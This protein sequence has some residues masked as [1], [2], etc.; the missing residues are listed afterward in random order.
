MTSRIRSHKFAGVESIDEWPNFKVGVSRAF[1]CTFCAKH[2][3]FFFR[4]GLIVLKLVKLFRLVLPFRS[5]ITIRAQCLF[6][7]SFLDIRVPFN[8]FLAFRIASR[9]TSRYGLFCRL[10]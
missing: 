8:R 9:A 3:F 10:K 6:G 2:L 7:A 5:S 4:S 1:S